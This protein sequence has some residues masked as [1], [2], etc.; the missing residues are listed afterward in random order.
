MAVTKHVEG[1]ILL[2]GWV[3]PFSWVPLCLFLVC[4]LLIALHA[5]KVVG[6]LV[7]DCGCGFRDVSLTHNLVLLL[8]L[9]AVC[10]VVQ[11]YDK[12]LGCAAD[13]C[14]HI[15]AHSGV[16]RCARAAAAAES[17]SSCMREVQCSQQSTI[18]LCP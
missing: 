8:L 18:S 7:N 1:V 17:K 2:H 14:R 9:L 16:T 15:L 10:G 6:V 11:A 4:H 5:V 12:L 3:W 13:V